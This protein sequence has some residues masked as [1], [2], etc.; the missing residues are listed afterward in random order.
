MVYY[1]N[2]SVV[3]LLHADSTGDGYSIRL[4][5]AHAF[6]NDPKNSIAYNI[7]L[8]Q[9]PRPAFDSQFFT[10][11][12]PSFIST[13]GATNVVLQD[14]TPGMYFFGVR[15]FEYYKPAF[16]FSTLPAAYNGL[17]TLPQTLLTQDISATDG[18][19]QVID[20][21]GFPTTNGTMRI[22]GELINYSFID[23]FDNTFVLL[24]PS[25]QRGYN[26]S[27]PAIHDTDGYDGYY[28][29]NPA[30]IYW[31]IEFEEQNNHVYEAWS[32]FDINHYPYNDVDGYH[33]RVR[34]ILTT[35]LD[36]S[37]ALDNGF[38]EY[39][40]SGYHRT[41]PTLLLNG[42][43]VG[44]YLFGRVG[45]ADGYLGVGQ[46]VTGPGFNDQNLQRQE[47][48]LSLTGEPCCLI[49]RRWTGVTCSCFL[50]YNEYPE[51][52]CPTCAGTGFVIGYDQFFYDRRSDGRVM[53]RFDPS[54]DDLKPV[55]SGLESTFN[56]NSWLSGDVTVKSRDIIVRFDVTGVNEEFRY[57][58]INVTRNKTLFSESGVE[59]FSLNRIRKTDPIYQ[60]PIF[61]DTSL[62][63]FSILTGIAGSRGFPN[64]Q[65][66]IRLSEKITDVSQINQIT[67]TVLG[68]SHLIRN[69]VM[70]ENEFGVDP[71][72]NWIGHKHTIII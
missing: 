29:W 44:S 10:E 62:F 57:E 67:S 61:R 12:F 51:A 33:Q 8:S 21:E 55:D 14:L 47:V 68:H 54:V 30:V 72:H 9:N 27:L 71:P 48:L 26:G 28:F 39:D 46:M 65:H 4:K 66:S 25:T 63:P 13:S 2:P 56:P 34:D 36:A 32:R 50:P 7:Y 16:D 49:K 37:D 41:D 17:V 52:R 69:G 38:P 19:I 6:P 58:I 18:Y 15:A 42:T 59:K 1:I 3:G 35:P 60:I 43:C 53:V 23:S 20:T 11:N 70:D 22:G 31:P 45:C 64:H 40:F 24:D 5:W